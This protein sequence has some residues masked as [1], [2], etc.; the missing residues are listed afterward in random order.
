MKKVSLITSAVIALTT[1]A[2][3]DNIGG[4]VAIGLWNHDPSGWIQNP[5]NTSDTNKVDLDKDLNLNTKSEV[6]IRAKIEHPIP[7]F[8]NI[9]VAY[10]QVNSNGNTADLTKTFN[11]GNKTFT[12]GS[13][14]KTDIQLNSFD[15]SLYYEIID[16]GFDADLGITFRYIDGYTEIYAIN[17]NLNQ[18]I[19]TQVLFPMIYA[20]VRVPLPFLDNLSIGAEGN[21][22]TYD[23]SIIYDLQADVRYEFFMG[24]GVEAGY[25]AQKYKFDDI[26]NT[27]S[28]IDIE[29]F[30]IGAV[31]DF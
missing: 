14:I 21:Y 20:N 8:P 28:D 16:I 9:R 15:T 10:T 6:Y 27:S 17:N 22:I 31:W 7:L 18:R 2:M 25:R 24:L 4:E 23:G 5:A 19:D 29:G 26:D 11:F 12:V 3:A 30:F 1:S 13:T